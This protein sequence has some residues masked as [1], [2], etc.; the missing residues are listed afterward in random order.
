MTAPPWVDDLFPFP[1]PAPFALVMDLAWQKATREGYYDL[2]EFG[3]TFLMFD[4]AAAPAPRKGGSARRSSSA[5]A[6][7]P[8]RLAVRPDE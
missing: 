1:T 5:G 3:T 2:C 8:T 6:D 4:F 7:G